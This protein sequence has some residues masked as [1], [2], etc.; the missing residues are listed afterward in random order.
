MNY[1]SDEQQMADDPLPL[2]W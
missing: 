1:S 2:E